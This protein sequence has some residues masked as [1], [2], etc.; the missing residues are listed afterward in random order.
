M[1][2]IS[3]TVEIRASVQCVAEWKLQGKMLG[4]IVNSSITMMVNS[5]NLIELRYIIKHFFGCICKGICS[6]DCE[7]LEGLR[8]EVTVLGLVGYKVKVYLIL[9]PIALWF[10]TAM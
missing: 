7:V 10:L 8:E 3:L 9:V 1:I 6:D 2:T 5:A 4:L